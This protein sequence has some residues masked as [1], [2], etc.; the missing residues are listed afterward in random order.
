[1]QAIILAAGRGTRIQPLSSK[2]EKPMLQVLG[3]SILKHNLDQ[4]N[5][6]VKEVLVVVRPNNK[7]KAI[8]KD[9]GSK[10]RSL[11]IK[12]IQQ[13]NSLGTG[14]A[15]KLCLPFLEGK[16]LL[17]NGDDFYSK[18][19]LKK[20]LKKFP[21]I[22]VKKVKEPSSFGVINEK[23]GRLIS[24][25]EKPKNPDSD[26]VNTGLYFL[27]KEIFNFSIKKSSRR[28]YEFTDY[29]KNFLRTKTIYIVRARQW[30]PVSYP[31]N[32]LDINSVLLSDMN[33]LQKGRIENGVKIVG[34]TIIGK[35]ALIKTKTE[36]RG[37]I[38]IGEKTVIE[39]NC[40][41]SKFTSIGDNCQIGQ[42][43]IIKNCVIG[44]YVKIRDLV[45]IEDSIIAD[46]C[47]LGEGT[48]VINFRKGNKTII[49]KIKGKLI[50]TGKQ[51]L[52]VIMGEGVI[53]GKDTLIYPGVKIWPNKRTK[54]NQAI[55]K[56]IN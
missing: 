4:L 54:T 43:S 12:Y 28:E 35:G 22:L 11:K 18:K 25:T 45:H 34:K 16:F 5:G 17:L 27:P 36:L 10:Y 19:D 46:N 56:D 48:V 50:K 2:K 51:K 44:N 24:L 29:I 38:R 42:G 30:I 9:I 52:G 8:E 41:L 13:K 1:M 3:K 49:S 20:I 7:G 40:F 39:Q 31:W 55:R 37:P 26:L 53:T 32:I 14:Y 23:N 33:G 15:A 47:V 21:S 6:L